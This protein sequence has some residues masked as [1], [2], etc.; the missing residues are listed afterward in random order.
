LVIAQV[1]KVKLYFIVILNVYFL[2]LR[3]LAKIETSE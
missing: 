3:S 2:I 1:N